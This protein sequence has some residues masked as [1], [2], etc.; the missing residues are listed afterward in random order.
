M[1]DRGVNV[2]FVVDRGVSDRGVSGRSDGYNHDE[3]HE[4]ATILHSS[5]E[6]VH[7][8]VDAKARTNGVKEHVRVLNWMPYVKVH[9]YELEKAHATHYHGDG[10]D[11]WLYARHG[12]QDARWNA[13]VDVHVRSPQ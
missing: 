13:H 6:K 9:D 10:D 1:N 8:S 7:A 5:C 3:D 2:R 4:N 12:L 11:V